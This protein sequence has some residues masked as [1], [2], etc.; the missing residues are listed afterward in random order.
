M[1]F[2]SGSSRSSFIAKSLFDDP[3]L[4]YPRNRVSKP[5][6]TSVGAKKTFFLWDTLYINAAFDSSCV[7]TFFKTIC[8][9]KSFV[10]WL[11][12]SLIVLLH[13]IVHCT[14]HGNK[15]FI[16]T[17]PTTTGLHPG[18][19]PGCARAPSSSAAASGPAQHR[20]SED[21]RW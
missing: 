21:C 7:N 19:S 13:V 15:N 10:L 11:Q 14:V 1:S 2:I 3:H 16:C 20:Q 6:K 12:A 4:S 17:C 9:T 18:P 5:P 8:L